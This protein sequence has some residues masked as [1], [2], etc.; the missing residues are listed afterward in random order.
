MFE[1]AVTTPANTPST[2]PLETRLKITEGIVDRVEIEFP[3]GCCG[4]LHVRLFR[5]EDQLVPLNPD[6]DVASDGQVVRAELSYP[7]KGP[8]TDLLCR[9]WNEDDTYSH[10]V[11]IR[12]TVTRP[13]TPKERELL[14]ELVEMWR[15]VLAPPG[16]G[17]G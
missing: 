7:V 8:P 14:E 3:L 11:R 15:L 17:G 4:L 16:G 9:S 6:G 1:Y 12:I 5:G 13:A 10:T 2:A